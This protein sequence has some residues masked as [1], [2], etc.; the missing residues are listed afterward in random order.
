MSTK[1]RRWGASRSNVLSCVIG[2]Q[3]NKGSWLDELYPSSQAWWLHEGT[4]LRHLH[5]DIEEMTQAELQR[6]LERLEQR[7]VADLQPPLWLLERHEVLTVV[8]RG[9]RR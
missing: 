1:R 9:V 7:L 5:R 2:H 6:E 4:T 8:L 3:D